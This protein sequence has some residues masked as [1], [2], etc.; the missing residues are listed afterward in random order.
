MNPSLR[1]GVLLLFTLMAFRRMSE[2]QDLHFSQFHATPHLVNPATAGGFEGDQRLAAHYRTQWWSVPVP[3]QTLT[4]SYVQKLGTPKQRGRWALGGALLYDEAGDAQLTQVGVQLYG[5]YE[6]A[7]SER[8]HVA[9]GASGQVGQRR[10][11]A[12]GLTFD[13]QYI[14]GTYRPQAATGED[15]DQWAHEYID[16]GLGASWTMAL[17]GRL[18]LTLGLSAWHLNRPDFSF[19]EGEAARLPVKTLVHLN[20]VIPLRERLDLLPSA[21][22]ALQGASYERLFGG[23]LRYMLVSEA[24]RRRALLVGAW[25]RFNDSVIAGIGVEYGYWRVG[26]SYDVNTSAFGVATAGQGALELSLVHRLVR[27]WPP[28]PVPDCGVF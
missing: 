20:G 10:F 7:V 2:A 18:R 3:Y 6:R 13:A 28:D 15:F 1:Y 5:S 4:A 24:A 16:L 9:M 21:M 12:S 26:L 23:Y 11:D 19:F 8:H 17:A 25:Y 14:D 27:V 22:Y